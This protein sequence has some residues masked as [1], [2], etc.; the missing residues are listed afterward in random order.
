[1]SA[2]RHQ[3]PPSSQSMSSTTS[4]T[5][6]AID[7]LSRLSQCPKCRGQMFDARILPCAHSFCIYCIRQFVT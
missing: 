3:R 4:F 6:N 7:R 1:M 2:W 5:E